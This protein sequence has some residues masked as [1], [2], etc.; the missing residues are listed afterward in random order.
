MTLYIIQRTTILQIT[1]EILLQ[2]SCNQGEFFPIETPPAIYFPFCVRCVNVRDICEDV[3]KTVLEC[4]VG[5][6][7]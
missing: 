2:Y 6:S 7:S 5:A 4:R 1:K 3:L